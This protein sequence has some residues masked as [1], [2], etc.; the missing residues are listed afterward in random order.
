MGDTVCNTVLDYYTFHC[1]IYTS[2]PLKKD[3]IWE[4]LSLRQYTLTPTTAA[5]D[6]FG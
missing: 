3:D 6:R 1:H 4:G 5:A 2:T